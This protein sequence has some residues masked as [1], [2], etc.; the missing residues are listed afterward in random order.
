M[1]IKSNDPSEDAIR[2]AFRQQGVNCRNI[3]SPFTARLCDL[4]AARL[5]RTNDVGIAILS[6]RGDAGA[7][8]DAVPLRLAGALHGLVLSG[9]DADLAACYPP[10]DDKIDDDGLWTQIYSYAGHPALAPRRAAPSKPQMK[11]GMTYASYHH[12]MLD[13]F[14]AI[15]PQSCNDLLLNCQKNPGK[16]ICKIRHTE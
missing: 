16:K 5:D 9:E 13:W 3:G 4:A 15:E 10:F 2:A 1:S 14:F 12:A 11:A 6:Y 8:R 7:L